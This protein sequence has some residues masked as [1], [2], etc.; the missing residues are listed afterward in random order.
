MK[1]WWVRLWNGK[2]MKKLEACFGI[3]INACELTRDTPTLQ[4]KRS[5]SVKHWCFG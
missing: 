4:L 2:E 5:L 3:R 1:H